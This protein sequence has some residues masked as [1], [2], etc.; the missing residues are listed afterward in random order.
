MIEVILIFAVIALF[1]MSQKQQTTIDK[2]STK[3]THLD[4][5]L[6]NLY[7]DAKT[8]SNTTDATQPS[9]STE[10]I[11]TQ[12]H[13]RPLT[14]PDEQQ[15]DTSSSTQP[16]DNISHT[17]N[18]NTSPD[19]IN[20]AID[21]ALQGVVRYFSEGNSIVRV[22]MVVLFF[23]MSFLAK[24]S[25]DQGWVPIELRMI[26]MATLGL[27][28]I[29]GGWFLKEKT[30]PYSLILQGGG[31]AILFLTIFASHRLYELIPASITFALLLATSALTVGLSV[32]QNAKALA[33][34]G[35]L[36]GFASPI[37]ASTGQGSHV[38]LFVYYAILNLSIFSVSWFKSW[39]LLNVLG[40]IATY[41][42]ATIWGVLEYD[43]TNYWSVQPF[44]ILF[45]LIFT[46][47]SILFARRQPP[48]L[49]GIVDGTL[50]FGT[51]IV[52]SVLQSYI[53]YP[54]EYGMAISSAILALFY[55]GLARF[56]IKKD[57]PELTTLK[58]SFVALSV[59]FATLTIPLA[60][61]GR[62]TSAV[63]AIEGAAFVWI[64]L[65]Q[66]RTLMTLFG[67]VLQLLAG[68][69]L[70]LDYANG[71]TE[72]A[73]PFLNTSFM[74]SALLGA[75]GFITA[76]LI[77]QYDY[78]HKE[79][80]HWGFFA[81][82]VFWWYYV[83]AVQLLSFNY[84]SNSAWLYIA[85]VTLSAWV[86]YGLCVRSQFINKQYTKVR[87]HPWFLFIPLAIV[88]TYYYTCSLPYQFQSTPNNSCLFDAII[89]PMHLVFIIA[90]ISIYWIDAKCRAHSYE[91]MHRYALH[92][93]TG[94]LVLLFAHQE[95][96]NIANTLNLDAIWKPLMFISLCVLAIIGL[97]H[98]KKLPVSLEPKAYTQEIVCFLIMVYLAWSVFGNF[99]AIEKLNSLPYFPVLNPHDVLQGVGLMAILSWFSTHGKQWISSKEFFI[100]I[101]L[102]V[103]AWF[104]SMLLKVLHVVG[105]I[106]YTA[107]DLFESS[108][109][110]M[111]VSIVWVF[112][113]LTVTIVAA[114]KNIRSVW[115]LGAALIAL[116]IAK[117]FTVDFA[118]QDTIERIVSFII[119]GL[120]LLTMGYF[121]PLPSHDESKAK[122]KK[123][124]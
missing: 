86:W 19:I 77:Q 65:K 36:G 69:A 32:L 87:M 91:V 56:L 31:A 96:I 45:F 39:R 58:E 92:V 26:G 33:I 59:L 102:F 118:D 23:G 52:S 81:I 24:H 41:V 6:A 90:I 109:V 49:K 62:W 22:G 55:L 30:G 51:P 72:Y 68:L 104:N 121:A 60:F 80:L 38:A 47:I 37:L 10:H 114:K 20:T 107:S 105:N 14:K 103:F 15:F 42:V 116:V 63:W 76:Y 25:I 120:L 12:H 85:F 78:I 43:A 73:L 29:G 66:N 13:N 61:D 88:C 70:L 9:I 79:K 7:N 54:Y 28:L 5:V 44:I 40:F 71:A 8:D 122:L 64:G 97:T 48:E 1:L 46:G 94:V 89:S 11:L 21:R 75:S 108:L 98:Y 82:G 16:I 101:G 2:L 93:L 119:V 112:L 50:V 111:V 84:D 123:I 67:L 83:T 57:A 117:L 4:D 99:M 3:L 74:G 27:L 95:V 34:T 35:L 53:V 110:Q 100:S 124:A 115:L 106:D 18:F 17:S 113:G